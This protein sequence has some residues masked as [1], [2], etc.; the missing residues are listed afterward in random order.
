M[1][2][3]RGQALVKSL[4]D[5]SSIRI[6]TKKNGAGAGMRNI[7]FRTKMPMTVDAFAAPEQDVVPLQWSIPAWI[8]LAAASWAGVYFVFSLIF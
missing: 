1:H 6:T 8:T 7:H 2:L 5:D 4:H 3:A